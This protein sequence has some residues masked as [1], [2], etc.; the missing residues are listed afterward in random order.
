MLTDEQTNSLVMAMCD[1]LNNAI[2]ANH[3]PEG[4][5]HTDYYILQMGVVTDMLAA[6]VVKGTGG[7]A[8]KD[9]TFI[10]RKRELYSR[11][12]DVMADYVEEVD[13]DEPADVA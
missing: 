7:P 11:L 5:D 9:G 12:R 13:D 8:L 2:A 3:C 6:I 1:R 4:V 10:E